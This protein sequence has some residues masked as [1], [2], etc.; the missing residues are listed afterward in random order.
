MLVSNRFS[1]MFGRAGN[2]TSTNP[3][4]IQRCIDPP[5][6]FRMTRGQF[7][8]GAATVTTTALEEQSRAS[9]QT[10][11]SLRIASAA[12]EDILGVLYGVQAGVFKGAGLDVDVQQMRSGSAVIAAVVGGS[13]DVGKSSIISLLAAHERGIPIVLI[14]SAANYNAAAPTIATI[15]GVDAPIHIPRDLDGKT[16]SVSSLND[17]FQMATENWVDLNGGDSKTLK[18][19]ELPVAAAAA[20]IAA[21]RVDAATIATPSLAE[22]VA[23]GQTRILG[24]PLDAIGRLWI[25]AGFFTTVDFASRN[26]DL[27]MR[28]RRTLYQA[29]GFVNTH[30]SE[31]AP[32]LAQFTGIPVTVIQHMQRETLGTS[33]EAKLLEPLIA[34]AV[35]YGLL[36]E[37]FDVRTMLF[38]PA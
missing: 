21:G 20:A 6:V 37:A 36:Q 23:S 16:I 32:L 27:I 26:R 4:A 19:V 24:R 31:T 29:A 12:D 14:A 28:F 34:P 5:G 15:V 3:N 25:N 2:A 22:A 33:M 9:G 8:V 38:E 10:P 18:F 11:T 17:Q 35:K 1:L 13:L 7:V 30:A